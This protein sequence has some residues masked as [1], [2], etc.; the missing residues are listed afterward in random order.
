LVKMRSVLRLAWKPAR[1][2]CREVLPDTPVNLA[3]QAGQTA[4]R[5]RSPGFL[6]FV[7]FLLSLPLVNPWVRGD[8]VGYY[9][10]AR[11]L[12]F[13]HNLDFAPDYR[14][15]N[16][17]FRA[18]RLL[19][20][21]QIRPEYYTRT[22]H[23]ENHFTVGPAILWSP[24]LLAAHGGVLLARALGANVAADGYALPYRLAMAVATAVYGFLGLW[25]AFDIARRYSGECW[26]LAATLGIWWATSLPVYMYFNPSWSHAHSA[27]ACTLFLWYWL[28]TRGGRRLW[29]WAV[30]GLLAGLMINVYFPNAVLLLT[31]AVEVAGQYGGAVREPAGRR[32]VAVAKLF[33]QHLLFVATL[34]AALTP[35]LVTRWVIYGSP[36]VTGYPALTSWNWSR[37]ALW[38]VAF[39]A[40]HGLLSW[41]PLLVAAWV[42]LFLF[43]RRVPEVGGPL[44][45]SALAFYY[46]IAS[47]PTWDGLSSFGNRFFISLTPIFIVGLAVA[48]EQAAR[49]FSRPRTA[50]T[51][52][53]VVLGL[54]VVWNLGFIFQWGTHMV[55]ARGPICWRQMVQNQFMVVPRSALAELRAYLVRRGL[56]MQQIE[57]KDLEQMRKTPAGTH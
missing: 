23:L 10:Y 49:L 4:H 46:L 40:D 25:L 30:L 32:V 13:G 56:L 52:V 22:G 19:P 51:V 33:G 8:G 1:R 43:W 39:S 48:L 42:G 20:N 29:R 14:H 50:G 12:L 54:C 47:Y 53:A 7:I 31:P 44:L 35:T 2:V 24:W 16:L 21:G 41:T 36:F 11:A 34:V 28:R 45:L 26:A 15:A 37:P 17:S 5:Q 57:Q 6:L 27:F 9:A 3:S 18:P 38:Q 55:P